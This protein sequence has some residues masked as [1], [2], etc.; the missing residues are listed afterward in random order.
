[1][2]TLRPSCLKTLFPF[3]ISN[4]RQRGEILCVVSIAR[5]EFLSIVRNDISSA[6]L[7]PRGLR[8]WQILARDHIL[9]F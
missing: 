5:R 9:T 3:V 2:I 7:I 1:M 4:E 8:F 6:Y